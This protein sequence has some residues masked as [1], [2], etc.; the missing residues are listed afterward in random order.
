MLLCNVVDCSS[1]SECHCRFRDHNRIQES[2]RIRIVSDEKGNSRLVI[3]KLEKADL[4]L[5]CCTASNKAGEAKSAATLH[6]I[7]L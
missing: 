5:Y 7:G 4:G 2:D 6:T 3:K 1:P